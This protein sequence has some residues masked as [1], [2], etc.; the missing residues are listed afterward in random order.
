MAKGSTVVLQVSTG[1]GNASGTI[2]NVQGQSEGDAK[3]ALRAAGFSSID[4]Q[5]QDLG[6]QYPQFDGK[7]IGTNPQAGATADQDQKITLFIGKSSNG[8]SFGGN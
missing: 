1:N 6:Q 5:D 4:T 8:F 3:K 2:P 7:A